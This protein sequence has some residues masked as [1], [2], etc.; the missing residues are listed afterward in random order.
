MN[1]MLSSRPIRPYECVLITGC[2]SGI[3]LA[4]AQLLHQQGYKV[5]AAYRNPDDFARLEAYGFYANVQL[6]LADPNSVEQAWQ[7]VLDITDQHIYA[8]FNNAAFGTP[9]A[10]ED[11]SRKALENQFQTNVFGTHQLTQLAIKQMLK[12]GY[13]RIIHNSSV[14]GFTAMSLRGSYNAS[15][16]ALE[17]LAATQRL[18]LA[19]DPI[20]LVLL[21]PGPIMSQ[22][23]HNAYQNFLQ[24]VAGQ[25]SRHA[26]TYQNMIA[27]LTANTAPAPF[28]LPAEAVAQVLLA[29]LRSQRPKLQYRITLPSKAFH[30]LRRLLPARWLDRL[31]IIASGGGKR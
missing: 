20:D 17:G 16:F 10:L 31:L 21:Q 12:Q 30:L 9:G 1:S 23:R 4:S 28:T 19:H 29:V 18:E 24:W 3:G 14:L 6:D 11:I 27:R 2:S 25:P 8:L 26:Q 7:R 22:F 13:G 5:I 15:K